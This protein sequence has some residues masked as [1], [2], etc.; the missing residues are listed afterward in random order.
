LKSL[1]GIGT[2]GNIN[3]LFRMSGEK[4]ELP[5]TYLKLKDLYNQLNNFSLKERI[6]VMKLN[7][8]RAD[9]IIPA[10]EI[11][12]TLMKWTGIKQIYV[13]KVGMVDGI[14]NLLIEENLKP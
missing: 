3:K 9:V 5:L 1:A 4:D 2:G 10:C 6:T 12:L 14:I 13:P 7:Q 8:D 11:F